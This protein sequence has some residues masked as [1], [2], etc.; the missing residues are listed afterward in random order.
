MH[1]KQSKSEEARLRNKL[2]VDIMMV[3]WHIYI[4]IQIYIYDICMGAGT[5]PAGAVDTSTKALSIG[6]GWP[7]WG[8]L[9]KSYMRQG[10]P[11]TQS[12]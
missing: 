10:H 2:L 12:K 6:A 7:L 1:V 11:T 4:Y 9:L 3:C 5:A 8:R